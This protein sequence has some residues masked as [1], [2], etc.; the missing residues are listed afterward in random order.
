M[1]ISI[2]INTTIDTVSEMVEYWTAQP[3]SEQRSVVLAYWIKKAQRFISYNRTVTNG[4]MIPNTGSEVKKATQIVAKH[5]KVPQ[6][7]SGEDRHTSM[8]RLTRL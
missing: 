4:R 3:E 7:K 6:R 1:T 5:F 2:D 8:M